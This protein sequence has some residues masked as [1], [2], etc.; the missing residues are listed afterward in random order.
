MKKL[1]FFLII[2]ILAVS[3]AY[4]PRRSMNEPEKLVLST[5]TSGQGYS[6]E[7]EMG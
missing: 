6:L 1:Y 5:N 4:E 3:C 7:M 2:L